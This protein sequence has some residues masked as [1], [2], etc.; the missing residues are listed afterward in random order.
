MDLYLIVLGVPGV[1][2][3]A[4]LVVIAARLWFRESIR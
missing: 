4:R 3:L 2:A 1:V